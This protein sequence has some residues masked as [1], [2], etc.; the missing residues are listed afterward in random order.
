MSSA[1]PPLP[2]GLLRLRHELSNLR[3]L[4]V[5]SGSAYFVI[6]ADSEQWI[7]RWAYGI[8]RPKVD[9]AQ[10]VDELAVLYTNIRLRHQR[11]KATDGLRCSF[12]S[13][14]KPTTMAYLVSAQL[15]SGFGILGECTAPCTDGPVAKSVAWSSHND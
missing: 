15:C 2:P 5:S 1:T 13:P 8:P 4:P 11:N 14:S 10:W 3:R 12:T 7:V 9:V 6:D